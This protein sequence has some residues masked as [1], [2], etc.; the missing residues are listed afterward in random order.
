MNFIFISP[1]FPHTYWEFCQRL[2]RNGVRVLGIADVPYDQLSAELEG[3]AHGVLPGEQS[4][5]LR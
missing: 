1:H 3:F 2:Q 4:G 5:E